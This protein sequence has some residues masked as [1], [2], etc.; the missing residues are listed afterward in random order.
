MIQDNSFEAIRRE[1]AQDLKPVRLLRPGWACALITFPVALF[2]LSLVLM[3]YG[4]REDAAEIGSAPLWVPA[5]LMVASAYAVLVLALIQRAP[6]STVSWTWW[7]VL[8][9][10]AMVFQ[11]ASAYWTLAHSGVPPSMGWQMEAMCFWRISILGLPPVILVL[12][13]C[14]A[15][16]RFGPKSRGSS[17]VSAA[18]SSPKVS[19]AS[20]AAC[21]IQGISCRGIQ[22]RFS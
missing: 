7:V 1:V 11:I 13:S 20:I 4:L 22:A 3:V 6:E 17:V 9:L 15:D 10:A 18:G 12:G 8:P 14:R 21:P 2:L 16:C 19:I 5:S